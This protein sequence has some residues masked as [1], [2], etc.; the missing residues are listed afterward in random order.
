MKKQLYVLMLFVVM[1]TVTMFSPAKASEPLQVAGEY[2]AASLFCRNK[3]GGDLV[4]VLSMLPEGGLP[5]TYEPTAQQ[6]KLLSQ[7][8]MYVRIK[9]DF[10]NAWW[11]KMV[12]ANPD[13]MWLIQLKVLSSLKTMRMRS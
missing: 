7:A 13:M 3:S 6:M 4:D 11:E 2:S 9:V 5:H 8:D 1:F 10:E 12:A